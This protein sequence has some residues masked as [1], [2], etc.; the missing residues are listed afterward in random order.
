MNI[1]DL[2]AY[3]HNYFVISDNAKHIGDFKI[4]NG[5]VSPSSFLKVGQYFRIVGSDLN[6]G[7]YQFTGERIEGLKDETFNGA[8]WA[9]SIPT[10]VLDIAQDIEK[11]CETNEDVTGDNMSPYQS[12]SFDGYSYS[13]GGGNNDGASI[14]WQS[15]FASRLAPYRRVR[16]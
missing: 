1:S 15:Q 7:V 14:S 11:W 12:E 10:N 9:M 16:I 2:C 6:D 4:E 8:I 13:K 3:L 5:I